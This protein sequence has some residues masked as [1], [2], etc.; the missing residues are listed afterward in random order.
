MPKEDS[1]MEQS[2]RQLSVYSSFEEYVKR[3]YPK[4]SERQL[5]AE[6]EDSNLLGKSLAKQALSEF[7]NLLSAIRDNHRLETRLS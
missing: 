2:T 5:M 7:Q 1:E 4:D 3:F 6:T